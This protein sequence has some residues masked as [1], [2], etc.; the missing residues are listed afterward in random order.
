MRARRAHSA[1]PAPHA[2]MQ[3]QPGADRSIDWGEVAE[4]VLAY[5]HTLV[6]HRTYPLVMVEDGS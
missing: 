6:Y 1:R 4:T 5:K 3:M 2:I